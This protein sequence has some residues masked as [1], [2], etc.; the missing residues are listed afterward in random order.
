MIIGICGY[1]E[2]GKDTAAEVLLKHRF[3]V[4]V[5]G[6][7]IDESFTKM[8]LADPLKK[9]AKEIGWNGSKTDEY[10]GRPFLQKLGTEAIK[11]VF[12]EDF[13]VRLLYKRIQESRLHN[14]VVPDVRFLIEEKGLKN[15]GAI[16][17]R[18]NRPGYGPK[19][20]HPSENE[21]DKIKPDFTIKNDGTISE[22]QDKLFK[23]VSRIYVP[24]GLV[25]YDDEPVD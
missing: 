4:V 22:L 18:I 10:W 24:V 12:G 8:S 21:V 20:N 3:N 13:W 16:L 11:P 5:G 23:I 15:W 1:A 9:A 6:N 2:V 14:I 7:I 19:N 25:D 17:I